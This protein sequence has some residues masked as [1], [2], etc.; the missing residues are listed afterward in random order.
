LFNN[1][2]TAAIPTQFGALTALTHLY[3]ARRRI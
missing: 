1:S 2:L 3:A